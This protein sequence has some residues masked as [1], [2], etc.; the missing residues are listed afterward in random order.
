MSCEKGRGANA[1]EHA[2][3]PPEITVGRYGNGRVIYNGH[4]HVQA[5]WDR[6]DFQKV[7]L[8]MVHWSMGLIRGDATPRM[9]PEK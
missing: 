7:W 9:R 1:I 6:P 4:G 2:A 3:D 8:E 5:V